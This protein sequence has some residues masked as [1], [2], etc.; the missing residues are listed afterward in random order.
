MK[1]LSKETHVKCSDCDEMVPRGI[2][3]MIDHHIKKHDLQEKTNA[4]LAAR[5]VKGSELTVD[6]ALTIVGKNVPRK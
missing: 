1:T 6:E 3:N 2:Q 5:T 4:M